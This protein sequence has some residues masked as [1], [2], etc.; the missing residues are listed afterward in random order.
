M[1]ST[2]EASMDIVKRH[3]WLA[4][5]VL[6]VLAWFWHS[7]PDGGL[8]LLVQT[9][10]LVGVFVAAPL[11]YVLRRFFA[12][13]RSRDAARKAM[14]NPVGAGLVFVGLCILAGMLFLALVPRALA[15]PGIG[16][17]SGD[18]K[19]PGLA[20]RDL[21]VLQQEIKA[22]WPGMPIPSML[23]ALVEQESR[24]NPMATLKTDREEGAGYGQFTRAYRADGSLR[25]DALAE[26]ASA[27]ASL[28]GWAWADRYNPRMQLRAVTVKVRDC[29]RRVRQLVGDDY[30]ALAMCDAA[31]NGGEGGVM[32]ERRLCTQ[33]TNCNPRIWFANVEHYSTK[34]R[35]K[36][37]GYGASA[38]EINRTHVRNVMV[39]RRHKYVAVLGA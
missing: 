29:H 2:L 5:V 33:A 7:D 14:E 12:E 6:V 34:S 25:F 20:S 23:A 8:Q 22:R 19:L 11:A 16:A 39:V 36:W 37:R 1:A 24:W 4:A 17:G 13:A 15:S 21:P 26:V 32:A 28:A 38:F 30:N 27:D 9:Q 35:V 18:A 10:T 31:Y 3:G